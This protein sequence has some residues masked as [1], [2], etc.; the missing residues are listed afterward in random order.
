MDSREKSDKQSLTLSTAR[1]TRHSHRK[2]SENAN[3][4]FD[5]MAALQKLKIPSGATFLVVT[6][7]AFEVVA[8]TGSRRV[9]VV[10]D[11]HREVSIKTVE[12]L[13]R[14]STSDGVRYKNILPAY[15]A[16]CHR[17]Q[18]RHCQIPR[19]IM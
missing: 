19:V 3:S 9:D 18:A 6:E 5:E 13:K 11:V 2:Y 16:Q 7:R 12:R 14:E 1:A 15:T 8:G 17:K 4:I 10:F